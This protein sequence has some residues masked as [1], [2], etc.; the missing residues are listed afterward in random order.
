ML[1]TI[2]GHVLQ[3][4][5]QTLLGIVFLNRAYTLGNVEVGF[6]LRSVVVSEIIS[7]SVVK[8]SDTDIFVYRDFRHLLGRCRSHYKQQGCYE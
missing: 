3:E 6:L 1:R 4:V 2:E 8:F 7:Q 5:S